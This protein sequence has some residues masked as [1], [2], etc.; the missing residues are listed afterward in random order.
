[1]Q[2]ERH[3]ISSSKISASE[4]CQFSFVSFSHLITVYRA[5]LQHSEPFCILNSKSCYFAMWGF[6]SWEIPVSQDRAL[7]LDILI[8]CVL[9]DLYV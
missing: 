5:K 8:P 3:L 9:E 7:F 1:M 4:V 6:Q 2:R